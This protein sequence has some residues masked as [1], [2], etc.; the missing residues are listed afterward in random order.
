MILEH[1]LKILQLFRD[2]KDLLG[3]FLGLRHTF[4]HLQELRG[5]SI[6]DRVDLLLNITDRLLRLVGMKSNTFKHPVGALTE[7]RFEGV[8][9]LYELI[10][11]QNQAL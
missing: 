6:G 7:L 5:H 10:L 9:E 11:E 8:R 2:H 4:D 3:R 1:F